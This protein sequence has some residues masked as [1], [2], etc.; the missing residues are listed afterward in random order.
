MS[1]APTADPAGDHSRVVNHVL[2]PT[3]G[4]Y[5]IDPVHTFVGFSAQ[6]LVVGRVRGRFERLAGTVSIG[7]EPTGSALDVTVE[8]TS[9]TTLLGARD[10][11]L[12]SERFLDV[13]EYPAMTYRS[14]SVIERP[15]GEWI[16]F[17]DLTI[18]GV[19]RPVPLKLLFGGS[20]TDSSG[21][22]RAAFNATTTITRS[23]FGI[24]AELR[25]EAGSMM[26][27]D[28]IWIDIEAEAVRS[29]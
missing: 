23:E 8:T 1:I 15:R 20:I 7:D 5:T 25:Q 28:D 17:G 3:A 19:T 11:D 21:K 9:I 18:R 29:E 14:T 4:L 27:A 26:I 13:E 6:H 10:D 16:V 2:V 24:V 12:R 22:P